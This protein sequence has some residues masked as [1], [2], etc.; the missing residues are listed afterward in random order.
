MARAD[1]AV[2][3]NVKSG[4]AAAVRIGLSAATALALGAAAMAGAR[5]APQVAPDEA[6]L[7][8]YAKDCAVCHGGD[9]AGGAFGPALKGAD[10]LRKWGGVSVAELSDYIRRSMPPGNSGSLPP[11]I[12]NAVVAAILEANGFADPAVATRGDRAQLA[13]ALL[14]M[15]T[16]GAGPGIGIGGVSDRFPVPSWPAGPDRFADYTPVTQAMLADPAPENWLAWRRSHLGQGHS[17]LTQI[18][19]ANVGNLRLAWAQPLPAGTNMNEPLVRDGVMYV[20]GFGDQIFALDAATGDVLW[21]YQRHV[22][23]GVMLN[24]KKTMALYGDRLFAATSDLHLVALDARTGRPVWDV[25]IT[26]RPGFRNPGGPLA[27]DGVVMQG[28]TTQAPGGALIA[29]FDAETG[30]HLWTFDTVAA[31]DTPGGDTWNGLP[32][33]QRS[34]GSVWT[35]GTYDPE[36]GLALFGTAPTY[37][38]GPLLERRAGEN[39][40]ALFTDT[41]LAL[42]PHTGELRW[43]FQHMKNDQWDLDW[44]F[45][46]TIGTL[47][48]DGN[49]RRVVMTSG[50]DGLVDVV[51][52]ADGRYVLTADMGLQNYVTAIDPETGDKT[53]DPHRLPGDEPRLICPHSAG[54]RNWTPSAFN[55][56]THRMFINA[57]NVCMDMVPSQ[58]SFIT[59]G[60]ALVY[61]PGPDHDGLYGVLQGIDMD[62][63]SIAWD[64]RQ[65]APY[66]QGILSTSGGLLFTGS[67]DRQFIA[68]DQADGRELWRSA[69]AGV[70]NAAP[71]SYAVDGRQYVA[72]VVGHGNPLAGAL[73]DLTPE[74]KAPPVNNSAVYV[75][76]LPD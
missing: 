15:P 53:I 71:I 30:R 52:A 24:S 45:E 14:P 33:D 49:V 19:T 40:D 17:P 23:E 61:T 39:N 3:R 51:D 74:I 12:H 1:R 36:T 67:S 62:D 27:A 66:T 37:D 42:D 35:S 43:Y 16:E 9:L 50:K 6:G 34:G 69:V 47:E 60:V 57:R 5:D 55:P 48:V 41:T 7:A 11:E 68:Y 20:Y 72:I 64:V 22:E 58:T 76:A 26:D 44:V 59:S 32:A 38:T 21:H 8:A 2:H 56:A 46:R 29:G 63:G 65:R 75:F 28:L 13:A 4:G 10:F 18:D 73:G 70:P 54:G 25:P 31:P